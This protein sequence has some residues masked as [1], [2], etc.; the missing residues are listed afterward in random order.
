[1]RKMIDYTIDKLQGSDRCF[2]LY[3]VYPNGKEC[4]CGYFRS[5]EDY[6]LEINRLNNEEYGPDNYVIKEILSNGIPLNKIHDIAADRKRWAEEDAKRAIEAKKWKEERRKALE[7]WKREEA[8]WRKKHPKERMPMDRRRFPA[9]FDCHGPIPWMSAPDGIHKAL[10][11]I[12]PEYS[13]RKC[14]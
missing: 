10:R 3:R 8:E 13:K 7:E 12:Y 14:K 9:M 5:E 4:F 1:M 11:F 2:E 6:D